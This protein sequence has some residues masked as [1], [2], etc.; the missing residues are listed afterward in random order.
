MAASWH[1]LALTHK[2]EGGQDVW[3]LYIDGDNEIQGTAATVRKNKSGAFAFGNYRN[4]YFGGRPESNANRLNGSFDYWRVSDMALAPSE[5][6]CAEAATPGSGASDAPPTRRDFAPASS[7]SRPA[8][9]SGDGFLNT[10]P[11]VRGGNFF[12]LAM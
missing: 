9:V 1:H 3:K 4:L 11:Q 8:G 6:L 2:V 7:S 5:F 12:L 10:L